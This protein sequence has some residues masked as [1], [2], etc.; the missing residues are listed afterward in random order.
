MHTKKVI[1]LVISL[2]RTHKRPL[3]FAL[4]AA[5]YCTCSLPLA[6]MLKDP[7]MVFSCLVF[8]MFAGL[9]VVV[10]YDLAKGGHHADH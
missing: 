9:T 6:V 2:A 5:L 8:S 1:S 7:E 3:V 10:I 4:A